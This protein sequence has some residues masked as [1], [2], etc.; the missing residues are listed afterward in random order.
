[1]VLAIAFSMNTFVFDNPALREIGGLIGTSVSGFFLIF[2]GLINVITLVKLW[3]GAWGA[4]AEQVGIS[5]RTIRAISMD[6]KEFYE[7][8]GSGSSND[9]QKLAYVSAR[10]SVWTRI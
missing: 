6:P 5:N 8:L 3:R 4:G 2:I 1:M 7:M 9:Q 10:L